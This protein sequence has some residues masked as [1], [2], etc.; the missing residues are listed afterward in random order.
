MEGGFVKE[1]QSKQ[2]HM[3]T[4]RTTNTQRGLEMAEPPEPKLQ[5]CKGQEYS[6][7]EEP[8][9]TE[10]EGLIV[11]TS[12]CCGSDPHPLVP[13]PLYRLQTVQGAASLDCDLTTTLPLH[14]SCNTPRPFPPPPHHPCFLFPQS[15]PAAAHVQY[16]SRNLPF[17]SES[18][19]YILFVIMR[20]WL[21]IV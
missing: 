20:Q 21:R 16:S 17:T 5:T 8:S 19:S 13:G 11:G 9:K 15:E 18:Y 14:L 7:K 10:K 1:V 6:Q 3:S 12:G 4:L 2:P